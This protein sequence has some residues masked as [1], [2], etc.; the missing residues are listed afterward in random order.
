MVSLISS[1]CIS[2][3]SSPSVVSLPPAK[4]DRSNGSSIGQ[5]ELSSSSSTLTPTDVKALRALEVMKLCHEF[6]SVL[7]VELLLAVRDHYRIPHEY[8]LYAPTPRQHPYDRIPGDSAK[9]LALLDHLSRT[10]LGS[11]DSPITRLIHVLL[12]SLKGLGGYYLT[13]HLGFKFGECL[14]TIKIRMKKM[15]EVKRPPL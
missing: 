9:L 8:V 12:S 1:F 11:Q 7:S 13:T 4:E 14:L 15:K 6:D 10:V 3:S 2:S 5:S